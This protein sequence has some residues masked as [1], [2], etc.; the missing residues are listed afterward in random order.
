MNQPQK[1]KLSIVVVTWNARSIIGRCLDLI[2]ASKKPWSYEVIVFDNASSDETCGVV[3]AYEGVRLVRSADNLGFGRGNNA[4][5]ELAMGEYVLFLNPDAYLEDPSALAR[6]VAELDHNPNLCGVGPRLVN[7]DGTHQVGDGGYSPTLAHVAAHQFL[8]SRIF[9][10][11]RGYYINNPKLLNRPPFE[12]DWIAGTCLMLR[13]TDFLAVGGFDPAIFMY[14]ED[15]Q[16]GCR[17]TESGQKLAYVP[18]VKVVHLQ[19]ATQ[20]SGGEL[21][22]S[23][24]WIDSLFVAQ[25]DA[26]ETRRLAR[27]LAAGFAIRWAAYRAKALLLRRPADLA[28]ATA[29]VTYLRYVR[30]S[31]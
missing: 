26:A 5:T 29:M 22:V 13:R 25:P 28:R 14:G 24:K 8:V 11:V 17:L 18:G 15:V 4:A 21:Y 12:V 9:G 19:G 3:E 1:I 6:L 2:A 20:K 23:T 27:V 7:I 31:A 16:L 30:Q 10:S